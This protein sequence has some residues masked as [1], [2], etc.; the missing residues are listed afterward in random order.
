MLM[1]LYYKTSDY[2]KDNI[3]NF[4]CGN[5]CCFKHGLCAPASFSASTSTASSTCTIA[6]TEKPL[7]INKLK[8]FLF[9]N[10][11]TSPQMLLFFS[12][13]SRNK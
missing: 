3:N 2:E 11:I 5:V 1:L 10:Y 13:T 9:P 8:A 4:A 6:V 12:N 7:T